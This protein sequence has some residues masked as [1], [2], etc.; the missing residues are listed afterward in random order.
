MKSRI[1]KLFSASSLLV[2]IAAS[3][4]WVRSYRHTDRFLVNWSDTHRSFVASMDGV[5]VLG[6]KQAYSLIA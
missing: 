5:F 3:L 6:L 1:F 2:A 4:L